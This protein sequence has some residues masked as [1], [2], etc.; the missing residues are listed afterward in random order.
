[1]NFRDP[2]LQEC[3]DRNLPTSTGFSDEQRQVCALIAAHDFFQMV[4]GPHSVRVHEA[5]DH[6]LSPGLRPGLRE[7][8]R[9]G[10]GMDQPAIQF[11]DRMSQLAG[12]K[13]E[14][15]ADIPLNPS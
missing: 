10:S 13:L 9:R 4:E 3:Y 2:Q 5:V 15:G 6:L 14:N 8:Y 12:E 11:R 1:V 7:W